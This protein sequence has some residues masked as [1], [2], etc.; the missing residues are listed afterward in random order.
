MIGD[1]QLG[2]QRYI[3]HDCDPG[4]D[5][6]VALVMLTAGQDMY[7]CKLIGVSTVGGNTNLDWCT[8]NARKMLLM[9]KFEGSHNVY[10][11]ADRPLL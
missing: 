7:K 5:D 6:A 1:N 8:I 10:P 9:S 11:G 4:F 3:W 2:T